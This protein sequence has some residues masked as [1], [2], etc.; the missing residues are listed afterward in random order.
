MFLCFSCPTIHSGSAKLEHDRQ[1]AFCRLYPRADA[2]ISYPKNGVLAQG[3]WLAQLVEHATLYQ[4]CE[5]ES[6]TGGRESVKKKLNKILKKKK[7]R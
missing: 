6:H 2:E 5:F 7:K 4:G 3:T 1:R